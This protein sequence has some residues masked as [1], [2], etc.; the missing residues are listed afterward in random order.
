M[1][2]WNWWHKYKASWNDEAA[3][4]DFSGINLEKLRKHQ[5]TYAN[6]RREV[7]RQ[8]ASVTADLERLLDEWAQIRCTAT[9]AQKRE[10]AVRQHFLGRRQARLERSRN[11]MQKQVFLLD[12]ACELMAGRVQTND[13]AGNHA[14]WE[15]LQQVVDKGLAD[16]QAIDHQLDETV[17]L[18][19]VVDNAAT[20][21]REAWQD[22]ALAAL[23]RDLADRVGVNTLEKDVIHLRDR[24]ES[25]LE[26]EAHGET[27]IDRWLVSET[28]DLLDA[29][30]G[31]SGKHWQD[32][33]KEELPS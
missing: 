16:E 20:R 8:L 21:V 9:E 31:R 10:I 14:F 17:D 15:R 18:V 5:S 27:D 19:T 23:D 33:A 22:T 1:K 29:T 26:I 13:E 12:T 7:E 3:A 30:P 32:V 4:G 25:K 6:D 11:R 28:D 2:L 24:A